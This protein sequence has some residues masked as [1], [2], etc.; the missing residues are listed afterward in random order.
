MLPAIL[1]VGFGFIIAMFP[2]LLDKIGVGVHPFFLN[3]VFALWAIIA[4]ISISGCIFM[5]QLVLGAFIIF[6]S[7]FALCFV[8]VWYVI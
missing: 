1:P 3:P 4:G 7:F 6:G 5:R 8:Y 2:H